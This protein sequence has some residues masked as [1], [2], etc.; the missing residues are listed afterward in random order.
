MPS[1]EEI[2]AQVHREYLKA[3]KKL[4][5]LSWRRDPTAWMQLTGS[6][7]RGATAAKHIRLSVASKFPS[8][9][10]GE[11][12]IRPGSRNKTNMLSYRGLNCAIK[13][14]SIT[15][16]QRSFRFSQLYKDTF[17]LAILFGNKPH[18]QHLWVVPHDII[19][20]NATVQWDD[21]D[22]DMEVM[23][24][25]KFPKNGDIPSWLAPYGGKWDVGV[26]RLLKHLRKIPR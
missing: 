6:K 2:A 4:A 24:L 23:W 22:P 11:I 21:E 3:Q 12:P 10:L 25:N 20:K 13:F 14:S 1:F 17:D 18:D 16:N 8:V 5:P 15:K 19:K 26:A 9:S 7:T